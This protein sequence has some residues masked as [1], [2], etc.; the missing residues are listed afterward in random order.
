MAAAQ[1]PVSVASQSPQWP[2]P[3]S[4]FDMP[5]PTVTVPPSSAGNTTSAAGP[6]GQNDIVAFYG[7]PN[8][9]RMGILGRY[10]KEELD[11]KLTVLA[12]E[13]DAANG[14]RGIT[15]AFYLIYG[16]VW[17]E[18]K[19]GTVTG[20]ELNDAM[21]AMEDHMERNG[22][23]GERLIVVHQF[24]AQMISGCS[25]VT[26]GRRHVRLI[27]RVDGFGAP[28]EKRVNHTYFI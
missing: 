15:K 25:R 4:P 14:D 28:A 20:D 26:D 11:E 1:W 22:I 6:I 27:H 18:G 17:P 19:I 2:I 7:Y 9:R 3:A 12:T 16:T 8:S 23:E 5:L 21:Q 24:K 10:T 13:Y